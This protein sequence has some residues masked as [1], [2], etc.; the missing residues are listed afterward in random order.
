MA[1]T[2]GRKLIA[3]CTGLLHHRCNLK[4]YFLF[5][6]PTEPQPLEYSLKL[7]AKRML[8]HKTQTCV[9]GW[10]QLLLLLQAFQD[11][12]SGDSKSYI[13]TYMLCIHLLYI[14]ICF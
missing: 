3:Y 7:P 6:L 14:H 8:W 1:G 9:P 11:Q 12:F 10:G 13:H 2:L 5:V 4:M